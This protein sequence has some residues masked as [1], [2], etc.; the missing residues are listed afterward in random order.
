MKKLFVKQKYIETVYEDRHIV[1]LNE[2]NV[3]YVIKERRVIT[4]YARLL[5]FCYSVCLDTVLLLG[6]IWAIF[7]IDKLHLLF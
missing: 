5:Y 3:P 2:A 6:I 4:S 7:N 1:N